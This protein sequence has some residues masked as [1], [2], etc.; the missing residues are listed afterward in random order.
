MNMHLKDLGVNG[1][2]ILIDDNW[3]EIKPLF[4]LLKKESIS[5][6]YLEGN[7][8]EFD[9]NFFGTRMIFLDMNL[10]ASS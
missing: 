1:K 4:D 3:E 6:F 2:V 9:Y 5:C 7:S 10:W 8:L